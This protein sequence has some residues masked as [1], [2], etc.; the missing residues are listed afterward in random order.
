MDEN[1]LTPNDVKNQIKRTRHNAEL[2][3]YFLMIVLGI[4]MLESYLSMGSGSSE[5]IDEILNIL[6]QTAEE[7]DSIMISIIAGIIKLLF[8]NGIVAL[9]FVILRSIIEMYRYYAGQMA[10]SIKVSEHNFPEIYEKVKEYTQ[11]LNL[12]KQPEVYVRQMNGGLNAYTSWVFGKSFIQLNA[13]IVDLAYMENKDFDTVMFVLAHEFGHIYFHHVHLHYNLLPILGN[14][15]P[16]LGII[17]YMML[18][19]AREFSCD[20]VAQALTGDKNQVEC[21][22]LLGVG[23]HAYKYMDAQNYL[24]EITANHNK[25]ELMF[26]WFINFFSTHPIMPF[27]TKAILDP[28]KNSGRLI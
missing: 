1:L 9:V 18:S 20:R 2:V 5:A 10:Y 21:M 16:G 7:P 22:M 26:R 11:L 8:F 13:E 23:R 6:F 28:E 27:R 14:L 12:D 3:L 19:R 17:F 25:I 15:F 24:D 4:A